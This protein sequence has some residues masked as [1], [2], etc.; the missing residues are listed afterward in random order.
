MDIKLKP[1]PFCGGEATVFVSSE[2]GVFVI[3]MKCQTRTK[4]LFD[5]LAY[6]KPTNAVGKV[7]EAWNTRAASD[8]VELYIKDLTDG[9]V[10]KYGTDCHDALLICDG[11]L[12]YEN[13]QNG[14]GSPTGYCFCYEDGETN[15]IPEG[16]VDEER[17]VHIG[18]IE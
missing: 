10:R 12:E 4:T 13:F 2:G 8:G 18:I 15:W 17:Y 14:D 9:T 1:C 7:I 11:V 16:A 5:S 3:C 6:N